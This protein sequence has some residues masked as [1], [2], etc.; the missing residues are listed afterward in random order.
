M[1]VHGTQTKLFEQR[2]EGP[3]LVC[4]SLLFILPAVLD[5]S[6][7]KL[8]AF[9]L[10][11]AAQSQGIFCVLM[12]T[13]F[14]KLHCSMADVGFFGRVLCAGTA[15]SAVAVHS[16]CRSVL[17]T[18]QK[19]TSK[20]SAT[21][22]ENVTE[23]CAVSQRTAPRLFSEAWSLTFSCVEYSIL[24]LSRKFGSSTTKDYCVYI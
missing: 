8:P 3:L 7:Q 24:G 18:A 11:P 14:S 17:T 10:S 22:S 12:R 20:T 23:V 5:S 15:F 1:F 2:R 13:F 6:L 9:M 19:I 16:A 21:S 4:R